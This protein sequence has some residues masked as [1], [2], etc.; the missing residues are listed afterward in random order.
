MR[1]LISTV[2]GLENVAAAEAEALPGCSAKA[3]PFGTAGLVEVE[4]ALLDDLLSLD[5]AH[6]VVEI[7]GEGRSADLAGLEG[8]MAEADLDE[9]RD[10]A[11]FRATTFHTG[12][13]DVSRS[14]CTTACVALDRSAPL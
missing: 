8:A 5:T 14:L 3:R 2:P 9:L 1:W 12:D 6:H 4:G 13:D 11:S 7:R 10:A